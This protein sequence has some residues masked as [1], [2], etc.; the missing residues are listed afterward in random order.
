VGEPRAAA[1]NTDAT[2]RVSSSEAARAR[3]IEAER[4]KL[5]EE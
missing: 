1:D 3:E 5:V 2:A 4:K